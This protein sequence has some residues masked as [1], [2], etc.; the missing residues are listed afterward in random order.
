MIRVKDKDVSLKFYQDVMGM[1][2]IRDMK[3]PDNKFDLY[4]LAYT[5]GTNPPNQN[6]REGILEL[7]YNYGTEEDKDFKYHSGNTEPQGFGHICMSVDNLDAACERFDRLGVKWQ[8]RLTDGRMKSVAFIL[9]P[10]GY[11]I[12]IIQNE[13]LKGKM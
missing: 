3:N 1:E 11:W 5:H 9:D 2:L 12:E 4:F 13:K 8:K 10:D 7:T 6:Y